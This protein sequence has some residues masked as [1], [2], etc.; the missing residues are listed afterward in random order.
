MRS[1]RDVVSRHVGSFAGCGSVR[2]A[3]CQ[4]EG[5]FLAAFHFRP[6]FVFMKKLPAG[7]E[8]AQDFDGLILLE[9]EWMLDRCVAVGGRQ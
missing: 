9:A 2:D 3:I 4:A 8:H 7:V 1:E 5:H 6:A